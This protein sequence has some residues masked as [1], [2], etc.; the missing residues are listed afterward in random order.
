MFAPQVV[1]NEVADGIDSGRNGK[2]W[3]EKFSKST[4]APEEMKVEIKSLT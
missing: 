4:F 1:V 2:W 3:Q